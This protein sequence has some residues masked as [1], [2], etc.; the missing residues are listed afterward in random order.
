MYRLVSNKILSFQLL[1]QQ[2]LKGVAILGEFF[3]AFMELVERH[4]VL[5]KGPS[6]LGL[7]VDVSDLVDRCGRSG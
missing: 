3:D 4:G 7:I 5:E 6:E 2:R 1:P